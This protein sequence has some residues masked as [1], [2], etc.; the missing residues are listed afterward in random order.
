MWHEYFHEFIFRAIPLTILT[1]GDHFQPQTVLEIFQT[2]T[3]FL[4]DP[5]PFSFQCYPQLALETNQPALETIWP[6]LS[7][8]PSQDP[9]LFA[10]PVPETSQTFLEFTSNLFWYF[11]D[12]PTCFRDFPDP[13]CRFPSII[14][15]NGISLGPFHQKYGWWNF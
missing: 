13:F 2:P 8:I 7:P 9:N 14:H 10:Q 12:S 1:G 4:C 6:K 3:R 11:L 15:F 5:Y